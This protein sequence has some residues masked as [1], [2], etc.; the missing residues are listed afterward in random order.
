MGMKKTEIRELKRKEVVE[1]I[2]LRKEAVVL[3]A[4]VYKISQ[5]T[6]FDW[7]ARYR[8]G[9]WDGLKEGRKSGRPR[10]VEGEDMKWLYNAITL[11]SPLN[12]KFDFCLWTL[13]I[14]RTLLKKERGIVLSKSSVSRLFKHLGLT[15]QRPIHK[16]YKQNPDKMK[17]YLDETFPSAMKKAKKLGAQLYFVDEASVRSD[18]HS[19]TTWG[20][21]GETP[22]VQDSGGRFGLRVIS[23]VSPRGEM[24]FQFI[25][26]SMDSE[27][28]I[29]FLKKLRKDAGKAILVVAD[30][31]RYHHSKRVQAFLQENIGNI[32]MVFLPAYT[33][34]Y[35]PDEQVWNHAKR[36]LG[37]KPI[38]N[39]ADMKRALLSILLSIQKRVKL[40]KSFFDMPDTKYVLTFCS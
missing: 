29:R 40:I 25:E 10:K 21:R 8:H 16:S 5:R 11:G 38:T 14:A 35:N 33:P 27:R 34:E 20:K 3:V 32:M 6:I 9:G 1:A 24:R 30:N 23:A 4:R 39:K 15:P 31:A 13:A 12:Y 36:Q 28:F 17:T 22:V 37:Q 26:E 18:A 7:L 19:G 2:I